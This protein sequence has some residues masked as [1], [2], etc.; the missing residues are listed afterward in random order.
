M[1]EYHPPLRPTPPRP[2]EVVRPRT[3]TP[4]DAPAVRA[5]DP[6]G[7]GFPLSAEDLTR[8]CT[9]RARRRSSIQHDVSTLATVVSTRHVRRD[10]GGAARWR[11]RRCSACRRGISAAGRQHHAPRRRR[12]RHARRGG[13]LGPASD[14]QRPR[15]PVSRT[16]GAQLPAAPLG[17]RDADLGF[18]SLV[19]GTSAKILDTRKTTPGWRALEKYAVRARRRRQSSHGPAQWRPDQGQPPCRDQR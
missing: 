14:G 6:G 3:I 16:R 13:Y 8:P 4:L 19:H 9:G 10:R 5:P 1:S 7:L 11:H 2:W 15:H 18:V 17:H 12:R